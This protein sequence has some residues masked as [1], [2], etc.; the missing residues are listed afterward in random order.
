M[1]IST[2][3]YIRERKA[4]SM[5]KEQGG[6]IGPAETDN[7]PFRSPGFALSLVAESTSDVLISA[8]KAAEKGQ[9]PED[10]GV[11]ASKML[12]NEIRKGGCVDSPSQWLNLLLMVLAPED[13]GKIRIGKMTAFT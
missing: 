1:S 3:M 11:I 12:L 5:Y 10:V 7:P 8:E 4:E 9:T 2:L 13:V 6:C